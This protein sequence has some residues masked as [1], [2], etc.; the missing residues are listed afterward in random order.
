MLLIVFC[1]YF[2]FVYRRYF[3][4]TIYGGVTETNIGIRRKR[5][6]LK[7]TKPGHL[8]KASTM[9]MIKK[10]KK[11][12]E[13]N[14]K[15][16]LSKANAFVIHRFV[17]FCFFSFIFV[18]CVVFFFVL[19]FSRKF[20]PFSSLSTQNMSPPNSSL[21]LSTNL[22]GPFLRHCAR[23]GLITRFNGFTRRYH[24]N[25]IARI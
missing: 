9:K 10:K 19:F 3:K 18:F 20:H 1:N 25:T 24:R 17:L 21:H 23:P 12:K 16:S 6:S 5:L 2:L 22:K 4:I 13:T 15:R 11:R 8:F 7:F 14:G